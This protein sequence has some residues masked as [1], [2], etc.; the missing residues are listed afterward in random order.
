VLGAVLIVD[1]IVNQFHPVEFVLGIIMVGLVPTDWLIDLAMGPK[2]DEAQVERL[3]EVMRR[4]DGD[5]ST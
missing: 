5:E 4:K 1:S 2:S 3:R